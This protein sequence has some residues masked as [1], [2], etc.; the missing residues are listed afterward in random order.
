MRRIKVVAL[1]MIMALLLTAC[2]QGTSGQ[3]S[4]QPD[5]SSGGSTAPKQG[6]RM[7][8][9]YSAPNSESFDPPS[10]WT[11][12]DW[13]TT[14]LMLFNTLYDYNEKMEIVPELAVEMPEI[15][16]DGRVY[17]IKLRKGVKFHNGREMTADDVLYSLNRNVWPE[18]ESW[19]T[20]Y[21]G[22]V[23]GG[24]EA[25]EAGK[26]SGRAEV[27]GIQKIDDY[28]IKIELKE[29][30]FSWLMILTMT[31]N[32]VVP[33]DV[34]EAD[35]KNF[36]FKPVGTGPF[37]LKEWTSGQR[38]VL[39]RNPDYFKQGFPYLDE[40]EVQFGVEPG[41]AVMRFEKGEVDFLADGVPAP[42]V[43]RLQ[44]DPTWKDR[45]VFNMTQNVEWGVAFNQEAEPWND[46]RVRQAVAHAVDRNRILKLSSGMARQWNGVI[47][48][49]FTCYDPNYKYPYEYNPEKAK[50]LLR[51]A[52]VQDGLTVKFGVD[53][54]RWI[55][56]QRWSEGVQQDLAAVG[57]KL[58]LVPNPS[59]VMRQLVDKGETPLWHY[60]WGSSFFDPSDFVSSQLT[61]SGRAAGTNRFR[62]TSSELDRLYA[63]AEASTD[64]AARCQKYQQIQEI[65]MKDVVYVPIGHLLW[66][67][68]KSPRLGGYNW[69][70]IFKRPHYELLYVVN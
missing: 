23:K 59:A 6:G 69:H 53:K 37:K 15:S 70:P 25:I 65:T 19:G 21:F 43:A 22:M 63:E 29:P 27:S 51:E 3:S 55:A 5:G 62:W 33:K 12:Q 52:G 10:A 56:S 34:V 39:E 17:T 48:V 42:E 64:A 36:R 46:V 60:G 67:D 49:D 40:V 16:P 24:K 66:P 41:V 32:A 54:N 20:S 1:F 44:A 68:L 11:T 61:S 38:V 2:G 26:K 7:I 30:A 14:H 58:E 13:S 50:Q 31:F 28:T 18:A 35:P 47:P 8:I 57:I 9:A 4:G 45:L